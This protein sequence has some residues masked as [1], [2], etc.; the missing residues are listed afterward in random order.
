VLLAGDAGGFVNGMTAEGIY[1]AMV[2]GDLAAP[3]A[4]ADAS[5]MYERL[6]RREVGA[7]L[8]DAVLV[9]RYLL[10]TPGRIDAAL[11]GAR[12]APELADLL[13][14]YTMGEVS[15]FAARRRVLLRSPGLAV[16]LFLE[17]QRRRVDSRRHS[18]PRTADG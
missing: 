14:R 3:A 16:R 9:Q 2:S 12:R 15:Y 5:E 1:Y 7:E 17:A 10:T 11:A 18:R 4:A 8:R 6:W 13:V